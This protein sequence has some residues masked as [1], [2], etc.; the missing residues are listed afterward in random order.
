MVQKIKEAL[1]II[2][3]SLCTWIQGQDENSKA[4]KRLQFLPEIMQSEM[5][6]RIEH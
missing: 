1:N 6:Q 5:R 2:D 3:G 4:Q